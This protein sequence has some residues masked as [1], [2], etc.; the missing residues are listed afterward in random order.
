MFQ[1]QVARIYYRVSNSPFHCP[2]LSPIAPRFRSCLEKVL[3]YLLLK[4]VEYEYESWFCAVSVAH[5]DVLTTVLQEIIGV[6][7]KRSKFG[8]VD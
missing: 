8:E 2:C 6:G 7:K 1:Q 4:V 3:L 5:I